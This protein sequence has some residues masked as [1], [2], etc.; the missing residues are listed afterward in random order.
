MKNRGSVLSVGLLALA[1]L[2]ASAVPLLSPGDLALAVDSDVVS[3]SSYP[4]AEAPAN[5]L[6]G[7]AGTKYLNFAKTN[8]GFIVTPSVPTTV[9]SLRLT[10]ANDFPQR[11]PAS[12]ALYGTNDPIASA[13]N[14]TGAAENWTL[15]D[16]GT[17]AL[18]DTR[19]ALGPVVAVNNSTSYASYRLIFPTVKDANAANSVQ[20]AEAELYE[21]S[22]GSTAS[23]LNVGD[24]VLA[25]H[26]GNSESSS[27]LVEG[28]ANAVDG[29]ALTKYL[30]F[31][32]ENSGLILMPSIGKVT[33]VESFVITTANDFPERD[34]VGWAL[35]GTLDPI[36]SANDSTGTE[37]LWTL[38]DMGT[39]DLP[40]DRFEM[41]NPVPVTNA[42]PYSAYKF[43]VTSIRDPTNGFPS[44][45]TQF[46]EI[47]FD[48]LILSASVPEPATLALLGIALAGLGFS[49]RPKLH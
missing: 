48:G 49:R 24:P 22:N 25:I 20:I 35:Y 27:P 17:V 21:S 2:N 34:P 15:I 23:I 45:S 13:D 16:S 39:M 14:S 46:A 18:P 12:W 43:L 40:T 9:R 47:Q 32:R 33:V 26:L 3:N 42:D 44:D 6:D 4:G 28:P 36:T 5:A 19:F 30:N 41:G 38:I 7:N 11:D 1:S 8:A 10:T 29:D 31:G 37:E